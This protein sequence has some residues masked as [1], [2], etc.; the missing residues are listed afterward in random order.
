MS[1]SFHQ[2]G[3]NTSLIRGEKR[4]ISSWIS[5]IICSE[6][7]TLGNISIIFTG[8]KELLKMNNSFLSHNFH[9]D[10]I[11]FNYNEGSTIS[12]DLFIGVEL[13][14]E[15]AIEFNTTPRLELL[16]VIIHGV[17]HLTGYND[18]TDKEK[19][20][21]RIKENIALSIFSNINAS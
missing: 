12:G 9:T 17:F 13:V 19:K 16:R 2:Q 11:T 5:Q 7:K 6:K 14:T 1:V 10:I 4:K 8:K 3:I 15:N 20:Q 18:S 21:M